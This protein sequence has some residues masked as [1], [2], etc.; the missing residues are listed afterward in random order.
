MS[1]FGILYQEKYG[2]PNNS[3]IFY[4]N[5]F[6]SESWVRILPSSGHKEILSML[7]RTLTLHALFMYID[8]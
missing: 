7:L 4:W 1:L 8:M 2:N 3:A 5:E 6:A